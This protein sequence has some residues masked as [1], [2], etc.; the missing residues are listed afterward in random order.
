MLEQEAAKAGVDSDHS[1]KEARA[2]WLVRPDGISARVDAKEARERKGT[3]YFIEGIGELG[4][5]KI[6]F[7]AGSAVS[8]VKGLQTGHPEKIDVAYELDGDERLE[9][10]IHR[11]FSHSRA[12]GE[13]FHDRDDILKIVRR[14]GLPRRSLFAAKSSDGGVEG[15]AASVT[16]K[17]VPA[18]SKG[19]TPPFEGVDLGSNPGAGTKSKR[20]RPTTT[21]KPWEALGISRQAY[22]KRQKKE[23][24]K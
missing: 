2:E 3:V 24:T 16:T 1:E 11:I 5:L 22:Y 14:S 12:C 7:T 20:G 15:H 4:F 13:W 8:R 6:G 21:G 19:R 17:V 10:L 18:S 9:R 23:N